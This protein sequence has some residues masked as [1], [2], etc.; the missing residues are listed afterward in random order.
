MK[1][2]KKIIARLTAPGTQVIATMIGGLSQEDFDTRLPA[3]LDQGWKWRDSTPQA[4]IL[5]N[6]TDGRYIH[7]PVMTRVRIGTFAAKSR[8]YTFTWDAGGVMGIRE[9]GGAVEAL[10]ITPDGAGLS[11]TMFNGATI[12]YRVVA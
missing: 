6:P 9:S 12:E 3:L 10:T 5:D 7:R 2:T 11:L 1:P 4:Q 8:R